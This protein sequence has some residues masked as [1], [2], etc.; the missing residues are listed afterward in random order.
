MRALVFDG[1]RRITL[2]DDA[3]RPALAAPTDAVVR[4]V[5]CALCGSDLHPFRGDERGIAPGTGAA[6]AG[7]RAGGRVGAAGPPACGSGGAP[8]RALAPAAHPAPRA[9]RSCG[10]RGEPHRTRDTHAHALAAR[11][12]PAVAPRL[13]SGRPAPSAQAPV[14]P[15]LHALARTHAHRAVCRHHRPAGRGRHRP[16]AGR[17]GD[18]TLYRLVRLVLLLRAR[19]DVPLR[20]P[21]GGA[22]WV[23]AGGGARSGS[24]GGGGRAAGGGGR[25]AGGGGRAAGGGGGGRRGAGGGRR[26]RGAGGVS[27][28]SAPRTPPPPPAPHPPPPGVRR[29]PRRHGAAREPGTVRARASRSVNACQGTPP[30][31]ARPRARAL[32][33]VRPHTRS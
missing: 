21:G 19:R 4:V 11:A 33:R 25:A 6:G 13:R 10:P 9:A 7:E 29:A 17:P 2:V 30:P 8:V 16:R 14:T 20:A 27:A 26:G 18:G 1:V 28:K 22:V 32:A 15:T 3:P 12:A 31:P 5:L 23:A 24:A